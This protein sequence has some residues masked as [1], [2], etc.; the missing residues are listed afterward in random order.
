[1]ERYFGRRHGENRRLPDLVVIDGGKGQLSAAAVSLSRVGVVDVALCALAKREE[2][3][4]L[5]DQR[6]PLRLPRRS[7]ALR[8]LQ[9]I[10]DEA[11]RFGLEYHRLRRGRRTLTTALAGI[12]GIGPARQRALLER[13]GSVRA[14]RAATEEEIRSVP[15]FGPRRAAEVARFLRGSEGGD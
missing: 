10:R 11:H 12:P 8:L 14:L 13:F 1:M 9:R 4:Y 2:L 15:G 6:E 5:P 3:I 7:E